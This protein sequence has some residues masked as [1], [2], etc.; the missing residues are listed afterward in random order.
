M[1][2]KLQTG[3]SVVSGHRGDDGPFIVHG[4]ALGDNDVTV[5]ASKVPKQ[6]TPEALSQAAESLEGKPLVKNHVNRDID[7]VIG[8]VTKARHKPGV[9]VL[10]EAEVDEKQYAKQ[11]ER[12][13][14]Q[15]SPRIAHPDSEELEETEEGVKIVD[16]IWELQNLSLVPRGAAPSNVVEPGAH[17]EM[18]AAELALAFDYTPQELEELAAPSE[19]ETPADGLDAEEL[20]GVDADVGDDDETDVEEL[21]DEDL[22][23]EEE[24]EELASD[25]VDDDSDDEDLDPEGEEL[26]EEEEDVQVDGGVDEAF[27]VPV[28]TGDDLRA[29]IGASKVGDGDSDSQTMSS[30]D[31]FEELK[32]QLEE[33]EGSIDDLTL[34]SES[35][36]EELKSEVEQAEEKLE[37]VKEPFAESL[38]D[39]TS[40]DKETLMEKFS[41][42]ELKDE[43]EAR[44][45]DEDSDVEE[46]GGGLPDPKPKNTK[47]ETEELEDEPELTADEKEELEAL[48][49]RIESYSGRP[50]WQT[51]AE[52]AKEE[53]EDLAGVPYDEYEK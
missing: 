29:E 11:I 49:A 17:E 32:S 6:W 5:G 19:D 50:R 35:D 23:D 24:S 13:R 16:E 14:L 31:K 27:E 46:L 21:E 36:L 39:A 40:F 51:A 1:A 44:L 33:Y 34:V 22:V 48:E 52:N 9:G 42:E 26:S 37:T 3:S 53:F 45:D 2:V 25:E 18:S 12:G 30:E 43:Y 7:A 8:Q 20:D 4:I 15:V 47:T 38:A 10:F 41:F 28:L